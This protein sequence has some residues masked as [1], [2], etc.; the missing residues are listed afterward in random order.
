M[1]LNRI[2]YNSP[3]NI[4]DFLKPII[5]SKGLFENGEGMVLVELIFKEIKATKKT[6]IHKISAMRYSFSYKR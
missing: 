5:F 4:N 6:A 2:K 3:I 1:A